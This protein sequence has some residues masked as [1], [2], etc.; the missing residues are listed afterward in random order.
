MSVC[1]RV[2]KGKRKK[3]ISLLLF[4]RVSASRSCLKAKIFYQKLFL[5]EK[6]S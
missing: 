2:E 5:Y 6:Q 1:M 4:Q 3:D